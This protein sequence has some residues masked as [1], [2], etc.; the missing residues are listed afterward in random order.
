MYKIPQDWSIQYE[1]D[2]CF[3]KIYDNKRSDDIPV[4]KNECQ[5]GQARVQNPLHEKPYGKLDSS[6]FFLPL[7][8]SY[9]NIPIEVNHRRKLK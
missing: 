8:H 9:L 6:P 1:I 4:E 3:H 2:V 5:P 7:L